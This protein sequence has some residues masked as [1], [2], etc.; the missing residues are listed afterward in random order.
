MIISQSAKIYADALIDT[1]KDGSY[2]VILKDLETVD[3]ILKS[4][5]DLKTVLTTPAVPVEQ[6]LQIIND[7]FVNEVDIRIL[8]FLKI[9]AEKGRWAEFNQIIQAYK[10]NLDDIN[11][12]K[13]VTITSA[14]DL[15][16]DYKQKITTALNEKL[17]K[18]V[19]SVWQIDENIIG[20]LVIKIDDDVI[21]TSIKTKLEN[22]SKI[23]GN[24]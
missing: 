17:Q 2:D 15:S 6:K 23:K 12:I 4:S 18:N 24:I 20:G 22:I 19:Q 10:N 9:L 11:G 3:E 13:R 8:N 1:A 5:S 14:I 21:D 16:E 7:V